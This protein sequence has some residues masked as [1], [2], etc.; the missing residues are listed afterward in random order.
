MK[1][2]Y[3]IRNKLVA[4]I[5]GDESKLDV[6]KDIDIFNK[7]ITFVDDILTSQGYRYVA[8]YFRV[9]GLDLETANFCEKYFVVCNE[10]NE[11]Y[12]VYFDA[13]NSWVTYVGTLYEVIAE[14]IKNDCNI[15]EVSM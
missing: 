7:D 14:Q 8:P 1:Y 4:P 13:G 6:L 12:R 11:D 15:E 2:K 10:E 3:A 5:D 9:A